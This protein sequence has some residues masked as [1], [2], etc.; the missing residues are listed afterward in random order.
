[1][2]RGSIAARQ[3]WQNVGFCGKF[4]QQFDLFQ[5]FN[6]NK[7]VCLHLN[8]NLFSLKVSNKIALLENFHKICFVG[9]LSQNMLFIEKIS[10][11]NMQDFAIKAFSKDYTKC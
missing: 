3:F 8:K 11:K 2:Q 10:Q 1:M 7:S 5:N 4:P 6:K 9:K